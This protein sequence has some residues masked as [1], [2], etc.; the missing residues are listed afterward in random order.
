MKALN[1]VE[2]RLSFVVNTLSFQ[3]RDT[4]LFIYRPPPQASAPILRAGIGADFS[5]G[6]CNLSII[7]TVW[8]NVNKIQRRY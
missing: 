1:D 7:L 3:R 5:E 6:V 2:S 8:T 4:K